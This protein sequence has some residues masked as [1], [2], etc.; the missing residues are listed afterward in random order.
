MIRTILHVRIANQLGE[1][2]RCRGGIVHIRGGCSCVRGIRCPRPTALWRFRAS[3]SNSSSGRSWLPTYTHLRYIYHTFAQQD[4]RVCGDDHF[5]PQKR[6]YQKRTKTLAKMQ[7]NDTNHEREFI[8]ARS[9]DNTLFIFLS[10]SSLALNAN[11][12]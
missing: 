6:Q 5:E 7:S 2:S 8:K 10:F 3:T 9:F 11:N 12:S 4:I 1:D